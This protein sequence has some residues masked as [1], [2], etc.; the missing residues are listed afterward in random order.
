MERSNGRTSSFAVQFFVFCVHIF[1]KIDDVCR[2]VGKHVETGNIG[3]DD[4]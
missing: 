1:Q 2:Q 4:S 3:A